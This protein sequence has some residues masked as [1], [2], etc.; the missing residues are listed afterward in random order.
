MTNTD[1]QP[2]TGFFYHLKQNFCAGLWLFIGSRRALSLVQPSL[3]QCFFWGMLALGL[4]IFFGWLT[5]QGVGEFNLQGLIN[6]IVYP[7]LVLVSGIV[8]DQKYDEKSYSLIV[9]VLWLVL[10]SLV[11]SIQIG[12]QLLDQIHLV[13]TLFYSY[14]PVIFTCLFVWQSFAI[15]WI[16]SRTLQWKWKY[17]ITVFVAVLLILVIWQFSSRNQQIWKIEE[18][19]PTLS[20]Q[21]FYAQPKALT[22]ALQKIQAGDFNESHWYFMGVAGTSYQNVFMSEITRIRELFDTRF[23]TAGRSI[24]LINNPETA[25]EIP[26]ASKS[27]IELALQHIGKQMNRDSDVLFLY[28]TSHGSE[29]AFLMENAP[30]NLENIDPVWLRQ[31]LDKAGIRWRVIVISACRSGSFIPALQS[32][33]TLVITA[34][35]ADRDSFGCGHEMD[36]T[37]FG[38]ALFDQAMREHRSLKSAFMQAQRTVAQW[39]SVQGF[40]PSE[41]QWSLGKNI[42]F[43]LP[44]LEQKLFPPTTSTTIAK[45]S[46][47]EATT[48]TLDLLPTTPRNPITP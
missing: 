3:W 40:P 4:N 34:S 36:Y 26:F 48:P 42:E 8:L 38:R 7:L 1:V 22:D 15:V 19:P 9:T 12:V 39:E 21:I 37:Y 29:N 10:D 23:N 17:R 11:M 16:I 2:T 33:D 28:M 27:S 20:E 6:Y 43:M 13:P 32:P 18:V 47:S 35:S 41:P 5:T 45:P 24:S 14:I 46:N 31:T 30:L 44:Q 25:L